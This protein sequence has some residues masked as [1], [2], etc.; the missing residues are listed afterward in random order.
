MVLDENLFVESVLPGAILRRL[1]EQEMAA[2]RAHQS[3]RGFRIGDAMNYRA[4]YHNL[5]ELKQTFGSVDY[6]PVGKRKFYV[7]DI[8]GNKY[9]LVAAIHFNTQTL[10]VRFMM[11]HVEYDRGDW[12]K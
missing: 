9:R 4:P 5:V 1:S 12:K 7:F 3:G 2:Y 8:G 6:V 11:T 10:F